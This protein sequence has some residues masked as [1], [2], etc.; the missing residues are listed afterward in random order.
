[1]TQA[2]SV[3]M[4]VYS[5]ENPVFLREAILSIYNQTVPASEF[6]LVCDGPLTNELD[7]VVNEMTLMFGD[8][9]KVIRLPRNRGLG[10]SLNLGIQQC[11]NELVARMDS[12]DISRSDRCEKQLSIFERYSEIDICSGTVEE[13][14]T[15]IE[16]I[17]TQRVLPEHQDEILRFAQKRNPF[18]HPCV[19]YKKRAVE[20]AGGYQEFYLLEDYYVWIRMLQN[21]C[22]GYNLNEPLLWM[23]AGNALYSRRGGLKYSI[24]QVK[25]FGF[26]KETGFTSPVNAYMQMVVRT[27]VSIMPSRI[28]KRLFCVF[29][30]ADLKK[31][32][33]VK[34]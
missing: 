9:M 5:K 15:S 26:M 34:R 20:N 30:R 6:V 27:I 2:Y 28:R 21:G 14:D 24:S 11:S 31:Q 33:P 13:F 18:N 3:L 12:D 22:K 19:M 17:R 7:V 25:L 16:C 4:S 29:L 1:M 32:I 10:Y 23:R 8:R